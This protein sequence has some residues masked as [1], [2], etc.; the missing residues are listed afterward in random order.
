MSDSMVR[1]LG[2]VE[3]FDPTGMGLTLGSLWEDRPVLLAMIRH[4]G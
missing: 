1:A 3:V 4:F 2:E